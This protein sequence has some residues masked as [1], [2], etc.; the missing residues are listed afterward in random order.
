MLPQVRHCPSQGCQPSAQLE[1]RRKERKRGKERERGGGRERRNERDL[2]SWLYTQGYP[3]ASLFQSRPVLPGMAGHF[4]YDILLQQF[5]W[6]QGLW[7][8]DCGPET[9]E[10]SK[11]PLVPARQA[12]SSTFP[13]ACVL[14]AQPQA[15]LV[16]TSNRPGNIPVLAHLGP[17]PCEI[18]WEQD[19]SPT[20]NSSLLHMTKHRSASANPSSFPS[21]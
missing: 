9:S 19:S 7:K 18:A 21:T 5:W 12:H 8:G 20:S 4:Q 14:E 10:K 2:D 3:L 11:S 13:N 17:L 1:G 6:P 16:S 15:T